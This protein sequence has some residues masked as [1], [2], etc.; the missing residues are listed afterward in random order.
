M[1]SFYNQSQSRLAI[2]CNES[3]NWFADSAGN[4]VS[5]S[6]L[7]N[8]QNKIK[9]ISSLVAV[10]ATAGQNRRKF[11]TSKQL[12]LCN[13]GMN[14]WTVTTDLSVSRTALLHWLILGNHLKDSRIYPAW[15]YNNFIMVYELSHLW[16]IK[17]SGQKPTM[18][19]MWWKGAI[20][21]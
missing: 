6:T 8:K 16:A 11:Q 4:R 5:R 3:G 15:F 14:T 2:T 19:P 17:L 18:L 12:T 20:F 21:G 7:N 1:K 13:S 9:F 10:N